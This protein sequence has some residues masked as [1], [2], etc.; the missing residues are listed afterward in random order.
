MNGG[1]D[2]PQQSEGYR[3]GPK[4]RRRKSRANKRG[5]VFST[6]K[7]NPPVHQ[8]WVSNDSGTHSPR[9]CKGRSPIKRKPRNHLPSKVN[10]QGFGTRTYSKKKK[11]LKVFIRGGIM[12]NDRLTMNT[13]EEIQPPFLFSFTV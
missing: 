2:F 11:T 9:F 1:M 7:R 3:T 8:T 4:R 6:R 5:Q 12:S 10:G 13:S